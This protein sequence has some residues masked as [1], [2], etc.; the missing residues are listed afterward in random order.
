[1]QNEEIFDEE[2]DNRQTIP[3]FHDLDSEM[4]MI[5]KVDIAENII[6]SLSAKLITYTI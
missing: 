4:E 3:N 5:I 1:M 2:I 6:S